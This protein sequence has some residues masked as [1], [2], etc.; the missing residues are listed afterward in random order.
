MLVP[1]TEHVGERPYWDCRACGEPWPCATAKAELT[2]QYRN[3][4]HGLAVYLGSCLLEAIDDWAAGSGGP[5]P[6]LYERFL[7]WAGT[8]SH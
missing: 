1:R 4:P 8:G 6:D 2:D 7:G 3:F 5:P